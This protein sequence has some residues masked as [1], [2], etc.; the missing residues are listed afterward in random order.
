MTRRQR[1]TTLTVTVSL[2]LMGLLLQASVAQSGVATMTKEELRAKLD[3]PDVVII[4]VRLG[5]DWKASEEKIKGAMRV[6]SAEVESV[7][8]TYPKDTTLVLYCA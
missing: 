6:D 4:D 1:R 3:R 7:A 5:K 2:T 8:A